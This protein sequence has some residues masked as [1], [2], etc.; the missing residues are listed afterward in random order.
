MP[1]PVILLCVALACG[2][3]AVAA[4]SLP[5][6]QPAV[7]QMNREYEL[8]AGYFAY[9]GGLISWPKTPFPGAD[10]EFVIGILGSNPFGQHLV[11]T[12][13][14]HV[15]RAG[16]VNKDRIQD[17]RIRVVHYRSVGDFQ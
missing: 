8:K 7:Q 3:F 1:R 15:L 9:F 6:Q 16:V 10:R 4:T 12:G 2:W 14:G 17:K 5:A 11:A 13:S